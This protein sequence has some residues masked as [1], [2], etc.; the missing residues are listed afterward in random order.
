[1]NGIIIYKGKYG[2]TEQYARMLAE[3]TGFM[4]ALPE[5]VVEDEL[6]R[7][8][9]FVLGSS[10]YIGK[11]QL[12]QFM[13]DH[14]GLLRKKIL[15]IFIVCGTKP[16][17]REKTDLII[18]QNIPAE[19]KSMARIYFMR[20]R[21]NKKKLTFKDGLLLRMGAFFTRN[22]VDKKNMLTDYDEVSSTNLFPLIQSIAEA[23][24]SS[25]KIT[26]PGLKMLSK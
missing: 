7:Y 1:V 11:L 15:F 13:D 24:D 22:P 19:L 9:C 21:M 20:G 26:D 8:D 18:K 2:A 3:S 5:T 23:G 12:K 14:A 25:I 16:G 6:D 17:D 10:V 4:I